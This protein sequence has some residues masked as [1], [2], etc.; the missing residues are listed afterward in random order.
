MAHLPARVLGLPKDAPELVAWRRLSADE[1]RLNRMRHRVKKY[2]IATIPMWM[3]NGHAPWC[4]CHDC[5]W[6]ELPNVPTE[7][8]GVAGTEVRVG[9][10]MPGARRV[11][12]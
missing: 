2:G 1:R 7:A 8:E 3:W 10:S 6:G 4:P 12:R 11:Y 5:L 9:L